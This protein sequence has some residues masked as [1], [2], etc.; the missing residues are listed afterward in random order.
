MTEG[1]P[2][3]PGD[4]VAALRAVEGVADASITPDRRV[5]GAGTLHLTL[6]PGADEVAVATAVNRILRE[7]FGLAVDTDNV[8]VVDETSPVRLSSVPTL[9]D[10]PDLVEP[11]VYEPPYEAVAPVVEPQTI[12]PEVRGDGAAP[13]KSGLRARTRA[14]SRAGARSRARARSS[15]RAR[16]RAGPCRGP[17]QCRKHRRAGLVCSSSGCSS[18]RPTSASRPR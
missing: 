17:V 11:D 8:S 18:S 5:G 13:S 3:A 7:H 16:S 12:E 6:M 15:A 10:E 4:V 14:R 2:G 1:G 9:E